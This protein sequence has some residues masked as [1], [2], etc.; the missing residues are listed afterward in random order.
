M[1]RGDLHGSPAAHTAHLRGAWRV[2]ARGV[3]RS[4]AMES[5]SQGFWRTIGWPRMI[6]LSIASPA[7]TS[8]TPAPT[9]PCLSVQIGAFNID[10]PMCISAPF[11]RDNHLGNP[12]GPG[13]EMTL[14]LTIPAGAGPNGADDATNCALRLRCITPHAAP[15]RLPPF[16][17]LSCATRTLARKRTP[18]RTTRARMHARGRCQD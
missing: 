4:D 8:E 3:C 14:N 6:R 7:K 16:A 12:A 15:R 2:F 18:H 17:F 9:P 10:P 5:N 13:N 11:T 1:D